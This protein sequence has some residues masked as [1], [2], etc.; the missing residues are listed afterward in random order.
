MADHAVW[1][2]AC[3]TAIWSAGMH[4][5]AYEAN[6]QDSV[7]VVLDADPVAM[8]LRQHMERRSETITTA[9]E[10]LAVMTQLTTEQVRRSS[11]WPMSARGLSGQLRRLAPALRRIG[12]SVTLDH[13]EAHTGR[14]LVHIVNEGAQ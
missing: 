4:M 11:H 8:A 10:L 12:I 5:A 6:R 7:D 13:R 3:E 9:T 14:R 1:M 2:R